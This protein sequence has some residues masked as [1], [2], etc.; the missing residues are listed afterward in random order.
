MDDFFPWGRDKENGD[1]ESFRR[2]WREHGPSLFRYVSKLLRDRDEAEDVVQEAFAALFRECSRGAGPVEPRTWLF[3][4]C[5]N[6]ALNR[7][8]A[9]GREG[10]TLARYHV[11]LSFPEPAPQEMDGSFGGSGYSD[12]TG[13]KHR[14][15]RV[16]EIGDGTRL[17]EALAGLPLPARE[18][19][20]RRARGEPIAQIAESLGIPQGT[21]KSRVSNLIRKLREGLA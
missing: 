14:T 4:C 13:S 3:R 9:A 12:E 8:R 7:I 2:I 6:R 5:R 18:L 19:L 10:R 16:D 20:A 1:A 17:T 11:E 15:G 21:V